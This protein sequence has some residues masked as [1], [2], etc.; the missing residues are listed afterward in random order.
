MDDLYVDD[1]FIT[2]SSNALSSPPPPYPMALDLS[3]TSPAHPPPQ[4]APVVDY[5]PTASHLTYPE[6]T[7]LRR[8]FVAQTNEIVSGNLSRDEAIS[9]VL[10][11][12][13]LLR[14]PTAT[15]SL[16]KWA[17]EHDPTSFKPVVLA[18]GM[19]PKVI[20][21]EQF[22]LTTSSAFTG[23]CVN[24]TMDACSMRENFIVVNSNIRDL[25][26]KN[27]RMDRCVWGA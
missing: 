18:V 22:D 19:C 11:N 25:C 16:I 6:M 15:P 8:F 2:D 3:E 12:S 1:Y 14:K 5:Q 10:S 24:S 27:G 4:P 23:A 9:A 21:G 20:K 17:C 13:T 26:V 7:E